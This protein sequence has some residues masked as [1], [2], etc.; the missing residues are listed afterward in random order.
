MSIRAQDSLRDDV[1]SVAS[2]YIPRSLVFRSNVMSV[3]DCLIAKKNTELFY[4]L[5]SL[6]GDLTRFNGLLIKHDLIKPAMELITT[7][8]CEPFKHNMF[9]FRWL[10]QSANDVTYSLFLLSETNKQYGECL[11]K[12]GEGYKY[13]QSLEINSRINFI[14]K[15]FNEVFGD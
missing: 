15:D 5:A 6:C 3:Y 12:D 2:L 11:N 4:M 7:K 8:D 13:R 14:K 9:S 10:K 1:C